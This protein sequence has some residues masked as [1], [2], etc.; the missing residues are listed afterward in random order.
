MACT[1]NA[2]CCPDQLPMMADQAVHDR[3][4]YLGWVEMVIQSR[5]IRIQLLHSRRSSTF[6]SL[7]DLRP[8]IS[9]LFCSCRAAQLSRVFH[10]CQQQLFFLLLRFTFP[11]PLLQAVSSPFS[12]VPTQVAVT[13]GVILAFCHD[14]ASL[15]SSLWSWRG[16]GLSEWITTMSNTQVN[17]PPTVDSIIFTIDRQDQVIVPLTYARSSATPEL[18]PE[19]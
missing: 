10:L 14:F 8:V 12:F 7:L 5:Q 13:I 16:S 17:P 4:Q 3:C 15:V 2:N 11:V 9:F 1:S 19:V 6:H 18:H